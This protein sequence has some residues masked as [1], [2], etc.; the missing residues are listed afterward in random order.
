MNERDSFM[1][2][3]GEYTKEERRAY[4]EGRKK[5]YKDILCHMHPK[6]CDIYD[7]HI[8]EPSE[9]RNFC[10]MGMD[11]LKLRV[12][13]ARKIYLSNMK[14]IHDLSQLTID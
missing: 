14:I 8:Y 12:E 3:K 5:A 7:T 4:D 10:Y 2:T 11:D 9:L 6:D 1:R 13:K